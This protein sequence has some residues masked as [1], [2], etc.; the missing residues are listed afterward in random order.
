MKTFETVKLELFLNTEDIKEKN[1]KQLQSYLKEQVLPVIYQHLSYTPKGG[2]LSV[3]HT[4]S[5]GTSTTSVTG[6]ISWK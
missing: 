5:G 3:N 2:S 6:T 1:Q 4:T